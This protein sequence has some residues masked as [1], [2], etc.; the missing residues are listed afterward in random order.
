[1]GDKNMSVKLLSGSSFQ[2]TVVAL[3]CLMYTPKV[4]LKE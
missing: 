4:S 3:K 2:E 1:M